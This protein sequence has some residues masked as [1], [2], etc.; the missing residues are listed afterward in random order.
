MCCSLRA[1]QCVVFSE[2]RLVAVLVPLCI[3]NL[4]REQH[5]SHDTKSFHLLAF[6]SDRKTMYLRHQHKPTM[7]MVD[8]DC[9]DDGP[10]EVVKLQGL[11][12]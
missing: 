12:A 4:Q 6:D 9:D 10:R 1:E 7:A 8:V 2:R 5:T 11:G 3:W